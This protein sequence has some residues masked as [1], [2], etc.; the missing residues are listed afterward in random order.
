MGFAIDQNMANNQN[1][2]FMKNMIPGAHLSNSLYNDIS[3][4]D[5]LYLLLVFKMF[6][7]PLNCQVLIVI[8]IMDSYRRLAIVSV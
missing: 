7:F 6:F 2:N 8:S 4:K 3:G 5:L 1:K